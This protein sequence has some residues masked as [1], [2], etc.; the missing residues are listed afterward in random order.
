MA[1][2][3]L[4]GEQDVDR[5]APVFVAAQEID[6]SSAG[7]PKNRSPWLELEQLALDRAD[8]GAGDVA[9]GR[10]HCRR[11]VGDEGQHRLQ[12]VEVEQQQA[13]VVGIAKADRQHALLRLA[14]P[15]QPRQQQRPHLGDG[16]PDS[17]AVDAEQVPERH[18]M[19]A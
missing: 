12:V 10:R 16:G 2:H 3:Q 7:S 17:M 14:Q 11:I 1:G 15:H 5:A 8:A 18:R 13:L 4:V 6:R 19:S 9:V